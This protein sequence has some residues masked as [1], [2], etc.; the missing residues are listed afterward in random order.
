MIVGVPK[1]IKTL[2]FRI[3]LTP[4]GAQAL[5]AAGHQVL[6]ESGGGQGSGIEDSAYRAVGAELIDDADEVWSRADM[7]L[8]VKEPQP[9]EYA[10]AREGQTLFTYFHFAASR[11]LTEGML[12]TGAHCLAY[13]TLELDGTLPLLTP[14]SEVAGRMAVQEGAKFL[15]RPKGGRGVLLAGVPGVERGRVLI[16]GGGVVGTN[17]ATVA[18]GQGAHVTIMDVDLDRMRYLE[19][20]LPANVET[21]Y[22]TPHAIREFLPKTDLLVGAV[23]LTGRRA[24]TLVSREDLKLMPRRAVVVD[25]AVDQGGCLETT[26]PTTHDD[27]VYEV[28]GVLHYGV[29]NMPGAVARTSTYALTNATLPYALKLANAGPVQAIRDDPVLATAANT[30]GGTLVHVGVADAFGLQAES[31]R[32]VAERL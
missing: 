1:E 31:V 22:S 11:E 12:A 32:E 8:K 25:V 29:A 23:L 2:E 9:V 26:R 7:I 10:R 6:V 21:V 18:A 27:P 13:E 14:M 4:A 24:P 5:I 28:E 30:L 19:E 20:I 16:L 17:A 3:A 15:E